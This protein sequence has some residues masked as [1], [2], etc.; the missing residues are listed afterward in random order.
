MSGGKMRL[1]ASAEAHSIERG[2]GGSMYER[3]TDRARCCI[4][5]ANQKALSFN[6][7]YIHTEHLLLGVILESPGV[8]I[9]ALDEIGISAAVLLKT[10]TEEIQ[11][12]LTKIT[13]V[14]LP[15]SRRCKKAFEYAMEEARNLHHDYV[16]TEHLLLGLL[17]EEGGIAAQV[18]TRLGVSLDEL[19][20][21]VAK[22]I[23]G[24]PQLS[25]LSTRHGMFRDPPAYWSRNP[26]FH[27]EG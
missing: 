9:R 24:D 15:Q 10:L 8:G 6:Q 27:P 19:R 13:M 2:G 21:R 7:E 12:G 18:L 4:R 17:R 5:L 20:L 11:P 14:R 23:A 22:Q 1:L 26:H 3:F 25:V 16:G